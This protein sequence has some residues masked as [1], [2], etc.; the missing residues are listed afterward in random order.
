MNDTDWIVFG[1]LAAFTALIVG[2]VTFWRVRLIRKFDADKRKESTSAPD[3][4]K[5]GHSSAGQTD[6]R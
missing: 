4:D 2:L 6:K 5:H 3:D 1:I